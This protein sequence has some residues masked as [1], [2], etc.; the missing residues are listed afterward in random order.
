MNGLVEPSLRDFRGLGVRMNLATAFEEERVG[1][2][3]AKPMHK[4]MNI[5]RSVGEFT[6]RCL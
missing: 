1:T 5:E 4:S 3:F 6:I 2:Y